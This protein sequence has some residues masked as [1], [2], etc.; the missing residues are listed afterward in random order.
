M[1]RNFDS[2]RLGQV[3]NQS[4]D[5]GN[6][7]IPVTSGYAAILADELAEIERIVGHSIGKLKAVV[8][9]GAEVAKTEREATDQL[10]AA[11]TGEAESATAKL[12][13]LEARIQQL[14]TSLRIKD[15]AIA[16]VEQAARV[17]LAQM[18]GHLRD[19]EALIAASDRQIGALNAEVAR[20]KDGM[21]EMAAFVTMRTK[22]ITDGK[23]T[24][25]PQ[26]DAR[27]VNAVPAPPLHAQLVNGPA[28]TFFDRLLL[29]FFAGAILP[30]KP[31]STHGL[32]NALT[33]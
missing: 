10:V 15:A 7:A 26:A 9:Q 24:A 6:S 32:I 14:E 13:T 21:L 30:P 20:L 22:I 28:S 31:V 16:E 23:V 3:Q 4:A 29:G 2:L 12:A 1:S 8:E 11:L 17:K 25:R 5:G 18:E 27:P 33:G 19:K